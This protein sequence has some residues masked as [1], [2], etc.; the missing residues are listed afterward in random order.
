M[1]KTIVMLAA[2][3]LLLATPSCKKG[4]NDPFLSLSSRKGRVVGEWTVTG[5]ETTSKSTQNDG[6]YNSFT[7]S[8]SGTTIST[9]NTTYDAGSGSTTTGTG[10]YTLNEGSYTFEKDGTF[11]SVWNVT[12]VST[13]SYTFLG[14]TYTT[15]TTTVSTLKSSG[16]WSFAGKVKDEY[17]NKERLVL[18]ILSTEE[19]DKSTSVTTNSADN[20]TDTDEGDLTTTIENYNSGE[21]VEAYEIDQLKGKEMI[22]KSFVNESGSES[23]TTPGGTTTTD[24]NDTV[25]GESTYTLTAK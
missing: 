8:L 5:Y 6:D 24:I 12:Y 9:S 19:T 18:N 21:M 23:V 25:V 17:K 14:V 3:A 2:G 20:T 4:E 16:N 22:L 10:S 11:S 15:T 7:Q 13:A 1:K